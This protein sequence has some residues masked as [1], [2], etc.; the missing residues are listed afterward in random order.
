MAEQDILKNAIAERIHEEHL[1]A[2]GEMVAVLNSSQDNQELEKAILA[3][4]TSIGTLVKKIDA[5]K[6]N[7][8]DLSLLGD[9]LSI[10]SSLGEDILLK[11]DGI[12]A[13]LR[14]KPSAMNIRRNYKKL[15]TTRTQN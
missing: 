1:S 4:N 8:N 10:I 2:I 5:A 13:L 7:N 11:Q 14:L 15:R 3:S 6:K 9:H 12:I